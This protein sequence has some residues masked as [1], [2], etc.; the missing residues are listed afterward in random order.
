MQVERI[1]LSAG[2]EIVR[3]RFAGTKNILLDFTAGT[4]PIDADIDRDRVRITVLDNGCG[5]P[6]ED[7]ER[8]FQPFFTTKSI[9]RG[10]GLGLAITYGIVKMHRG[11]IW[12]ES[13]SGSGAV[14]FIELH[15]SQARQ[16]RSM[17]P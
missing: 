8:V 5:I 14:F 16:I 7:H 2:C 10:T 3:C 1:Y 12:F 4:E 6:A 11:S 17:T 9:G 15:V 13:A